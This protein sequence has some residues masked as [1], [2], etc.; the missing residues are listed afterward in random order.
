MEITHPVSFLVTQYD[1]IK[2]P[3]HINF[4]LILLTFARLDEV[5]KSSDFSLISIIH[6]PIWEELIVF[7]YSIEID[8]L[9]KEEERKSIFQMKFPQLHPNLAI[10]ASSANELCS[11]T[12][13]NSI[14]PNYILSSFQGY[15][16]R[17]LCQDLFRPTLPNPRPIGG[18]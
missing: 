16:S 12:I 17:K 6:R 13:L 15:I 1:L 2:S 18:A 7:S 9:F 11:L 3:V 4:S 10:I 8:L 5:C 14:K